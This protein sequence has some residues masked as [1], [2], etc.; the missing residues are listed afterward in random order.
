MGQVITIRRA[1]D[2]DRAA[3]RRLAA[4]DSRPAPN[5]E[6]ELAFAGGE[7]LA[8][9]SLDGAEA[10][11]DPFQPTGELVELLKLRVQQEEVWA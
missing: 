2:A 8:A 5:G 7:L 11:A 1:T 3:V 10:V 4:L 9:V 6:L